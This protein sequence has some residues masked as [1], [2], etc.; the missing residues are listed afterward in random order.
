VS[1]M[2]NGIAWQDK[3]S[4]GYDNVDAQHRRMFEMLS[5]LVNACMDG[6]DTEKLKSTI[7]FLVNYTVQHFYDE[8]LIQIQYNYPGYKRHK[9]IHEDFKITVGGIVAKFN[10]NGS[11]SALSNDVNKIM[12]RWIIN[13]IQNEDKKIGEFIHKM[14]SRFEN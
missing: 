13:H 7:D 4:I 11:S 6:S 3:Y 14:D 5:E 12:V 9:Q 2:I 10:E 8:E 1:D